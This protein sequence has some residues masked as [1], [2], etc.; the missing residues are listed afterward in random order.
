MID[1]PNLTSSND[2]SYNPNSRRQDGEEGV[3]SGLK[4]RAEWEQ[5]A[6]DVIGFKPE[7]V[8][9]PKDILEMNQRITA[10]YAEMYLRN[11][12]KF[13][14]AGMAAFASRDVGKGMRQANALHNEA[15][16]PL[17][18]I[19]TILTGTPTGSEL[20]TALG[21]G[22]LGVYA[23]IY[24]QHLA[25]EQGGIQEM[26]N[27]KARGELQV[28]QLNAWE[29]IEQGKVW[30]G[31]RQLLF[32]EQSVTLQKG[33]YDQ[34]AK[35]FKS[36]SWLADYMPWMLSSPIPGHDIAFTESV[37][38]GNLGSFNDRWKWIDTSMLPA[39][40]KLTQENPASVRE[41]MEEFLKGKFTR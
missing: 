9:H 10:A 24:W 37:P 36:M 15:R 8:V 19:G 30:D 21:K 38:G 12:L 33:V 41:Y 1:N 28:T 23:D 18:A 29:L 4:T 22:N 25:Y 17:I 7:S 40:K 5:A 32:Y 14:W 27:L 35:A 11:P 34:H 31:N 3:R 26:R 2:D 20:A 16:N 39:W 13:L 6:K